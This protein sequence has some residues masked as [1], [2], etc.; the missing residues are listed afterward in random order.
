MAPLPEIATFIDRRPTSP[1]TSKLSWGPEFLNYPQ[2]PLS[3]EITPD[4]RRDECICSLP[5]VIPNANTF[6]QLVLTET[7]RSYHAFNN[8]NIRA[9]YTIAAEYNWVKVI[10]RF[11]SDDSSNASAIEELQH[12]ENFFERSASMGIVEFS[13]PTI[14]SISDMAYERVDVTD[15]EQTA[16]KLIVWFICCHRQHIINPCCEV[17]FVAD[18]RA[19]EYQSD[20]V[21]AIDLQ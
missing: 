11:S 5:S 19:G 14:R 20:R 16:A 15:T 1:Q 9:V 6:S 8:C 21:S 12:T 2:L 17:L 4:D 13:F 7:A 18:E 10:I 3:I